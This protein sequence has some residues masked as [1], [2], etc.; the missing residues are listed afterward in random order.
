MGNNP[1]NAFD[2]DGGWSSEGGGDIWNRFKTWLS[3]GQITHYDKT[4][5]RLKEV[6]V[7]ASKAPTLTASAY[8]PTSQSYRSLTYQY[9]ILQANVNY[10][11]MS[12]PMTS[13]AIG[14]NVADFAGTSAV[15]GKAAFA[16]T[17]L[18][19]MVF[20]G[21][22]LNGLLKAGNVIDKGGFTVVG[23]A[24]QKHE[25]RTGSIFPKATGNAAAINVQAE[26]V[27]NRI[28]TNLNVNKTIRHHGKFGNVL[29]YRIPR[30]Q[31]ARFS[32]DGKTFIEFL[33]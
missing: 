32:G 11:D 13:L 30:G 5:I 9:N 31:G 1:V 12:N 14:R 19:R 17:S 18:N 10:N 23:R 24:L 15:F 8:Y 7:F 29:E 21:K 3:D 28:L 6:H 2:A 26:A 16:I 20:A 4:G 22:R 25:I 33:E 27:L